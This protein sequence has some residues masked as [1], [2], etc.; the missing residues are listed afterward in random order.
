MLYDERRLHRSVDR[1]RAIP[2]APR[3]HRSVRRRE[4]SGLRIDASHLNPAPEAP[5]VEPD[6][7]LILNHEVRIDRVPIVL[8]LERAQHHSFI[9]PLVLGIRWIER[10]VRSQPNWWIP[11]AEG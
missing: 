10:P 6:V 2:A 4:L 9:D 5:P 7:I 1:L 11:A 3:I 8:V